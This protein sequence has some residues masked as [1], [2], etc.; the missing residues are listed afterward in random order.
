[1]PIHDLG[2]RELSE[3]PSARFPLSLPIAD[4][5][6]RIA[7]RSRWLTRLVLY[8]WLPTTYFLV[9]FFAYEQWLQHSDQDQWSFEFLL[10]TMDFPEPIQAELM[11]GAAGRAAIWSFLLSTFL[12]FQSVVMIILIGLLAPPLISRDLKS[13]AYLIIFSRPVR[14]LDYI[15]GK[16]LIL[17]FYVMIVTVIPALALYIF[18]VLLSPDLHALSAT[19]MLPVKLIGA[20]AMI[21]IAPATLAL[22]F[23]ALTIESRYASFAWFAVYILGIVAYGAL[24][25]T[26]PTRDWFF[27]S[28]YQIAIQA[29]SEILGVEV[30]STSGTTACL[31]LGGI[32][33]V[34]LFI[35]WRRVTSP[36]RS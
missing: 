10:E 27:V 35:V 14:V 11:N 25:S 12:R 16:L 2:L 8:A 6:N 21:A 30:A 18:G 17:L 29:Q 22:C 5:G 36:L 20:T 26:D 19:A 4:T 23:S 7:S 28:L 24:T 32:L 3:R 33:V 34:S 13:R 15:L 1:M 9:A 31:S